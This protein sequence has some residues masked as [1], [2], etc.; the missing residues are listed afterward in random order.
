MEQIRRIQEMEEKLDRAAEALA[1]LEEALE[2][3]R[4]MEGAVSELDAYY[5]GPLWRRDFEDDSAGKLPPD[6]RRGVLTED[7][8]YD[9][10]TGWDRIRRL[11]EDTAER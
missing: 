2:R 11:L 7:A 8:L 4:A 9:L 5:T 6:L 10:L 1:G 3:C